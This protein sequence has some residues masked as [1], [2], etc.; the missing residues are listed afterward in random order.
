MSLR[1]SS[2]PGNSSDRATITSSAFSMKSLVNS[3]ALSLSA[4]PV[5]ASRAGPRDSP[6]VRRISS[7]PAGGNPSLSSP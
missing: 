1:T 6:I 7:L 4:Q 3:A 5:S 2:L